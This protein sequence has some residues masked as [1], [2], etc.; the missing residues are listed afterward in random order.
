MWQKGT[1]PDRY[2]SAKNRTAETNTLSVMEPLVTIVVSMLWLAE[3]LKFFQIMGGLFIVA[4]SVLLSVKPWD[5]R[6]RG[7]ERTASEGL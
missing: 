4:S 1:R 6:V 3:P 2:W 5:K 7:G